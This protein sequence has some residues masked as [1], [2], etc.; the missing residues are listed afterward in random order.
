M[1]SLNPMMPIGRQISESLELHLKMNKKEARAKAIELLEL[2]QTPSAAERIDDYPIQFSGG[3]A[4]ARDD[5]DGSV[6]QP[7]DTHR[8]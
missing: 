5:R 7:T 1:T 2:V 3:D 6:M 8:G 4:P